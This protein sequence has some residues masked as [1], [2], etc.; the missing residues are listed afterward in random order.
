MHSIHV[1][2]AVCG[3]LA[4]VIVV[5][6]TFQAVVVIL[7]IAGQVAATREQRDTRGVSQS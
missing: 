6:L 1:G 5:L 2:D 4:T 3:S 7:L